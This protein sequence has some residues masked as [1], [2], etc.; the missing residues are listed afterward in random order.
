MDTSIYIGFEVVYYINI[1]YDSKY[2]GCE[3]AAL[4]TTPLIS[5]QTGR[6]QVFYC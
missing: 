4:G 3:F 6:A 1:V 2:T 5:V